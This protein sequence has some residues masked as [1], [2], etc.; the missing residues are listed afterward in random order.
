MRQFSSIPCRVVRGLGGRD[1]VLRRSI[2]RCFLGLVGR[3]VW[4]VVVVV[5]EGGGDEKAVGWR[6][7]IV[8]QPPVVE[9]RMA[10]PMEPPF[11][12]ELVE[13]WLFFLL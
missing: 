5:D 7:M 10:L 3:L 4:W 8:V 6:R 13:T 12:V 9:P 2:D 1:G 11:D